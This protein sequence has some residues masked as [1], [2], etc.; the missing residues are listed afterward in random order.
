MFANYTHNPPINPLKE[1]LKGVGVGC[2]G[3][4]KPDP[5]KRKEQ[6]TT[7][8]TNPHNQRNKTPQLHTPH[9]ETK[10]PNFLKVLRGL[11]RSLCCVTYVVLSCVFLSLFHLCNLCRFSLCRCVV[12]CVCVFVCWCGCHLFL[13]GLVCLFH[14][15]F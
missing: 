4:C 10:H 12:I 15:V 6:K 7:T 3:G 8:Q 14:Y 9:I 5:T 13:V 2:L 1:T 11:C